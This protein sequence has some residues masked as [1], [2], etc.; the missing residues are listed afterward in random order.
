[1]VSDFIAAIASG[2]RPLVSIDGCRQTMQLIT[3]MYKSAMTGERVTFP[4]DEDD[5]WYMAIPAG[6]AQRYRSG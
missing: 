6:G 5:P 2:G 4:I 3:G 1:M